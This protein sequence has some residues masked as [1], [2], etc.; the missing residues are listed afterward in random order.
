MKKDIYKNKWITETDEEALYNMFPIYIIM[1][2][3]FMIFAVIQKEINIFSI[4]L[5]I[6]SLVIGCIASYRLGRNHK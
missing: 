1:S 2:S 6:T 3:L 5:F 4:V